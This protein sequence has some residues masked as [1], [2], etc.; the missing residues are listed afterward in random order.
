MRNSLLAATL[1]LALLSTTAYA[2]DAASLTIG[3]TYTPDPALTDLGAPKGKR[4]EFTM[5]LEKSRIFPGTDT[6]LDP[7]AKPIFKE[8]QITV[9]VPSAY[10]DGDAAPV[11]I[12]HDGPGPGNQPQIHDYVGM[13]SNALDNL[14]PSRD[15]ARKLPPF[16]IVAVQHGGS[17]SRNSERGLEYDTMS[18]RNARFLHDEV[19][20]AVLSNPAIRAAYPRFRLT[21]SPDGRTVMGCS[22]GATAALTAAWFRPE[23]FRRVL[24]YSV[25]LV[26]QQDDD[27]PEE[28]KFPLGAW[29][30]HS[31]MKLIET[32]PKKPLRVFTHVSENDNGANAPE[33]SHRNWVMAG[34]RMAEALKAKGYDQRFVFSQA[35]RHC[36]GQVIRQ[37]FADALIWTWKGYPGGATR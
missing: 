20:P 8:R 22:S 35:S 25:T 6:T 37:T 24:G 27:A 5:P 3:P 23:W 14:V 10:R 16:V 9:Y 13:A 18:D 1:S 29:E 34:K 33:E 12:I 4:F 2:A 15:P 21:Q 11:L 17:D 30:Y 19:L 31:G 32:S 28:A 26:D 36:D 7:Q